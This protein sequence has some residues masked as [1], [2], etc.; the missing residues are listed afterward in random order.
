MNIYI[1]TGRKSGR[2][3]TRVREGDIFRLDS[4]SGFFSIF[5]DSFPLFFSEND[6]GAERDSIRLKF[7]KREKFELWIAFIMACAKFNIALAG[8]CGQKVWSYKAIP[9][10]DSKDKSVSAIVKIQT[11]K[12]GKMFTHLKAGDIIGY[13]SDDSIRLLRPIK[14]GKTVYLPL[15]I[16]VEGVDANCQSDSLGINASDLDKETRKNIV[17]LATAGS[18]LKIGPEFKECEGLNWGFRIM[19]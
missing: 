3:L 11:N 12:P 5:R 2:I 9:F 7:N 6:R 16:I 8:L 10:S 19:K 4:V 14:K 17:F 18:G 1:K 13:C 15:P